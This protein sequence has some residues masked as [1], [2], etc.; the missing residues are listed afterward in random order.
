VTAAHH[1]LQHELLHEQQVVRRDE[2]VERRHV[3]L[4]LAKLDVVH[5]IVEQLRDEHQCPPAR[6]LACQ[7]VSFAHEQNDELQ[8]G[9]SVRRDDGRRE[10]AEEE[11]VSYGLQVHLWPS[12]VDLLAHD[13]QDPPH[14][15]VPFSGQSI[16]DQ[17]LLERATGKKR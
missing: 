15:P 9:T 4:L 13:P 7:R 17:S 8:S 16:A 2:R 6:R 1:E 3:G 5:Q 14:R 10:E 12:L 11:Q